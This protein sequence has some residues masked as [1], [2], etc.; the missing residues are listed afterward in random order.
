M[1][2]VTTKEPPVPKTDPLKSQRHQRRGAK[3]KLTRIGHALKSLIEESRPISEVQEIYERYLLAYEELQKRHESFS[4]LIEDDDEYEMEEGWMEEC[5][6][7]FLHHQISFRDYC[8]GETEK[9]VSSPKIREQMTNEPSDDNSETSSD[10]TASNAQQDESRIKSPQTGNV[11]KRVGSMFK[12]EKPKMPTFNGNVRDY[13]IF[14][15]D[16]QHALGEVFDERDALMILRSCLQGKPLQM[17]Q[18]IGRDFKAAWEQLDLVYGDPRLVA[19]AIIHDITK[20]RS[21]KE[22]EDERFCEFV[23]IVRRSYNILKEIGKENDANM[24]TSK[25]GERTNM[26]ILSTQ[27]HLL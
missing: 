4:E 21:L 20:F 12:M 17:I 1:D 9:T 24:E 27:T 22:G 7:S 8:K 2:E 23:N 5:Q 14:K 10:E 3:G 6:Q 16:F 25:R 19:D 18:G 26:D 15:A 13:C 11:Q